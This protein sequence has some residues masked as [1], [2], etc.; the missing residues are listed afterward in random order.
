MEARVMATNEG[1]A[2]LLSVHKAKGPT[3]PTVARNNVRKQIWRDNHWRRDFAAYRK[4]CSLFYLWASCCA[5]SCSTSQVPIDD[6]RFLSILSLSWTHWL[7][8]STRWQGTLS[9]VG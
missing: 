3:S 7:L 2:V 8:W 5:Q 9:V 4:L 1:T 6:Q